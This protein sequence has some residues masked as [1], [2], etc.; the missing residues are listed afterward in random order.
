M[1]FSK[2]DLRSG[3]HQIRM[4][5]RDI[6]KTAF[7]THDGDFEFLVMPFGLN[8]A[9]STFQATMNRILAPFLRKFVI[10]FFDDI[11]IYSSSFATHLQHLE[12]VL[13]CLKSHVFSK[14]SFYKESIDY[15]GHVVTSIGVCVD[16]TQD[17][18]YD[19][20]AFTIFTVLVERIPWSHWVLP[21]THKRILKHH[22]PINQL[23]MQRWICVEF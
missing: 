3:Y 21:A 8:K 15:L 14:C 20:V 7:R 13:V 23:I 10:V 6:Y 12:Q 11:L 22:Y 4:H 5:E 9:P 16:H 17:G 18:S 2:L 19:Q 1:V